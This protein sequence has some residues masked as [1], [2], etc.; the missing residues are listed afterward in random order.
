MFFFSVKSGLFFEESFPY[1]D[2]GEADPRLPQNQYVTDMDES[3]TLF[4]L[5]KYLILMPWNAFIGSAF[6]AISP[7]LIRSFKTLVLRSLN[8]SSC[9]ILPLTPKTELSWLISL[10]LFQQKKQKALL[11]FP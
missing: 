3:Y 10:F 6:S 7:I 5:C 9:L 8:Q 1:S 11:Y 4:K 2:L